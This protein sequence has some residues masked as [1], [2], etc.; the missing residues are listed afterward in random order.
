M[1]IGCMIYKIFHTYIFIIVDQAFGKKNVQYIKFEKD[2]VVNGWPEGIAFKQPNDYGKNQVK[3]IMESK[4]NIEFL[5]IDRGIIADTEG[6][7]STPKVQSRENESN[8]TATINEAEVVH[9]DITRK[10]KRFRSKTNS[11][12]KR[13]DIIPCLTEEGTYWLFKC[14]SK[15]KTN[16]KIKGRWFD[17]LEEPKYFVLLKEVVQIDEKVVITKDNKR[18]V[19]PNSYFDEMTEGSCIISVAAHNIITDH[20][21]ELQRTV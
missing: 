11:F 2:F 13:G 15:V 14:L 10:Q 3:V 21:Q 18:M 19:L 8:R 5:A 6:Q 16:G 20:L 7:G 9:D 12:V 1:C 17:L 4:D